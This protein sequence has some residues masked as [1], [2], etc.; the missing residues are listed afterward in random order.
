M[1]KNGIA[2][3]KYLRLAGSAVIKRLLDHACV[4]LMGGTNVNFALQICCF[5]DA[6]KPEKSLK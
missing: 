1:G 3:I 6:H 2:R 5:T 4:A